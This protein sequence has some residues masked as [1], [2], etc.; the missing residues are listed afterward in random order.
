M[1][2]LSTINGLIELAQ[3]QASKTSTKHASPSNPKLK[4]A[5][6]SVLGLLLAKSGNDPKFVELASTVRSAI[7]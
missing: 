3:T 6:E 4:D 1:S 2:K 7:R 5:I